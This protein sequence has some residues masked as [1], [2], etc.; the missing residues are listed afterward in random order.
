MLLMKDLLKE[1]LHGRRLLRENLREPRNQVPE[2]FELH[3][4][5]ADLDLKR[6]R[7]GIGLSF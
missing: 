3:T 5:I 7:T 2:Q 4:L 1:I 6:S